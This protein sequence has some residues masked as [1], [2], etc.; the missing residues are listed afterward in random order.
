MTDITSPPEPSPPRD[1]GGGAEWAD[2]GDYAVPPE[3]R[4][5][6]ATAEPTDAEREGYIRYGAQTTEVGE[7]E[8]T[9][10][11]SGGTADMAPVVTVETQ[12]VRSL[13]DLA[14][15]TGYRPWLHQMRLGIAQRAKRRADY[16]ALIDRQQPT[17]R[18]CGVRDGSV[19]VGPVTHAG[20][21]VDLIACPAHMPLLV[22]ATR[23]AF[24]ARAADELLPDGQRVA[25]RVEQVVAELL[26]EQRTREG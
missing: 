11:V 6:Y 1:Y 21:T 17:C 18:V 9:R 20:R 10:V 2:E 14:G 16:L 8:I 7:R 5:H 19:T 25:D 13:V 26:D 15:A 3:L 22:D 12:Q 4:E 24:A 23:R